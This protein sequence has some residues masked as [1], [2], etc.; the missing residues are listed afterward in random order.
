M[1]YSL[2]D[3]LIDYSFDSVFD[4]DERMNMVFTEIKRIHALG[5]NYIIDWYK[6]N[7]EK[8]KSN[9]DVFFNYETL[10]SMI[11]KTIDELKEC[12]TLL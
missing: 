10:D 1:G 4:N 5:S 3:D 11:L 2:Y 9:R 8:I 12:R 6:N 7:V